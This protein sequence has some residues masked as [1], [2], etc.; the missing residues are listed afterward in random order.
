M[1]R[2]IGSVANTS[3]FSP[4]AR[5]ICVA[6]GM[7]HSAHSSSIAELWAG[8]SIVSR[9]TLA[10]QYGSRAEFA[11]IV[12]RQVAPIDTSSPEGA[13]RALWHATQFSEWVKSER[14]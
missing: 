5:L 10:C 11:I 6:I 14:F 4:A 12:D 2:T 1:G 8:W 9:R 13:T 3:P 7:W